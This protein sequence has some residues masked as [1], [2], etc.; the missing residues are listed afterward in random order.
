MPRSRA[1]ELRP[2]FAGRRPDLR[3]G[4]SLSATPFASQPAQSARQRQGPWAEDRL[5]TA[6]RDGLADVRQ[7][8]PS[9]QAWQRIAA[10]TVDV[11]TATPSVAATTS[12]R[13]PSRAGLLSP[14]T[15]LELRRLAFVGTVSGLVL[16]AGLASSWSFFTRTLTE[17]RLVAE[18]QLGPDG[19]SD[20]ERRIQPGFSGRLVNRLLPPDRPHAEPATAKISVLAN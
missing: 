14:G 18:A 8:Q 3:T 6:L 4:S 17:P 11:R 13:P 10:A 7:A 15:W 20:A 2:S 16:A 12:T 5:G 1:D 9:A 19:F